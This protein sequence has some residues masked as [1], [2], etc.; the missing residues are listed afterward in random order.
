MIF[1][2]GELVQKALEVTGQDLDLF[3][4]TSLV[5]SLVGDSYSL[6][7]HPHRWLADFRWRLIPNV[8]PMPVGCALG[9]STLS[10]ALCVVVLVDLARWLWRAP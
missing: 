6:I 1:P 2:S 10:S 5:E 3:I 9:S 8:S 7:P 4:S